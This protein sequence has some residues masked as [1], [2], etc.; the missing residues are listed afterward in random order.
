MNL[1]GMVTQWLPLS[2]D[3]PKD[4]AESRRVGRAIRA[5]M[6]QCWFNA[7]KA[8]MRL[9][10]YAE[11]GYVEGWAVVGGGL[12]LEHGWVAK[13]GAIIDP[14]LPEDQIV[15]FPGLEFPGRAG[16]EAFLATKDGKECKKTPFFYSYGWGGKHHAGYQQAFHDAKAYSMTFLS[17]STPESQSL[18]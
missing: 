4:V 9:P 3:G 8:V 13:D 1:E 17:D 6:K 5:A 12:L 2:P 10:D 14:T 18:V 11:A 7:R 15:Y 16:I